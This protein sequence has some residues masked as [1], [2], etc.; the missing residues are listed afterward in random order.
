LQNKTVQRTGAAFAAQHS[1]NVRRR[2]SNEQED[3]DNDGFMPVERLGH[4]D[5][6]HNL[7]CICVS[8]DRAFMDEAGQVD[9]STQCDRDAHG[10]RQQNVQDAWFH[11]R[12]GLLAGHNWICNLGSTCSQEKQTGICEPRHRTYS[13]NP[14]GSP[15]CSCLLL[16]MAL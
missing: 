11:S 13:V 9:Q 8:Q 7:S 12:S 14:A 16:D 2:K 1:R 4:L 3:A 5:W 10:Q 6:G 15:R